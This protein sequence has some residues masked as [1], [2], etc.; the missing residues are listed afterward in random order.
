MTL[1]NA[2]E[3]NCPFKYPVYLFCVLL[4]HKLNDNSHSIDI[5][6]VSI[7]ICLYVVAK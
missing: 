3:L 6:K 4:I 2:P 5:K 1:V 7:V